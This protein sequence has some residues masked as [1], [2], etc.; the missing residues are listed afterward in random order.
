MV[1]KLQSFVLLIFFIDSKK[2][3]ISILSFTVIKDIE[4][5]TEKVRIKPKKVLNL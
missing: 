4:K 5:S 2:N 3:I 1:G